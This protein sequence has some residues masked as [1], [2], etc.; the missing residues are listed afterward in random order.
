M[1]KCL[2]ILI[3]FFLSLSG[4]T[5]GDIYSKLGI[6][7][8]KKINHSLLPKKKRIGI[9]C[10]KVKKKYKTTIATLAKHLKSQKVSEEKT[11]Y[12]VGI[13]YKISKQIQLSVDILAELDINK[14]SK[15]IK[16]NQAN[17][18]LAISL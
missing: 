7:V 15:I 10:C 8:P 18:R 14:P 11:H 12:G 2:V 9:E 4:L 1:N 3:L 16:D 5:A 13:D 6:S 17:I